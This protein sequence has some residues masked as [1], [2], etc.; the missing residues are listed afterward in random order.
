MRG[1]AAQIR[2]DTPVETVMGQGLLY[3]RPEVE[4]R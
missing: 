4:A 1:R 3:N 2:E